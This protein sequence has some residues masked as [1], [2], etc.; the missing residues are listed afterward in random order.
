M[1]GNLVPPPAGARD[2]RV[3]RMSGRTSQHRQDAWVDRT[4]KGMR[5]GFVVESGACAQA[6]MCHAAV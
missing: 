5:N 1:L 2:P 3:E 6:A 4:L